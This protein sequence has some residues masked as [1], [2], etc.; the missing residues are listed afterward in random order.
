MQ[1][2]ERLRNAFQAAGG[3]VGNAGRGGLGILDP[4]VAAQFMQQQF[5]LRSIDRQGARQRRTAHEV[6]APD[7][8]Q[9]QPFGVSQARG[10]EG[11]FQGVLP[12]G[13]GVDQCKDDRLVGF[14]RSGLHE[15]R[16]LIFKF[17]ATTMLGYPSCWCNGLMGRAWPARA[18]R[19]LD[20]SGGPVQP[21]GRDTTRNFCHFCDIAGMS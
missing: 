8:A 6:A 5:R 7:R 20:L 14:E 1:R 12:G 21:I 9:Q 13:D 19:L 16:L 10:G 3:G 11:L 17:A 2:A 4:A 18:A 15:W